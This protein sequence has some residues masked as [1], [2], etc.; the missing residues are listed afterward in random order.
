MPMSLGNCHCSAIGRLE[1]VT[2]TA[3]IF[4]K[5][6]S[7]SI[8]LNH[9]LANL[10]DMY[11]NKLLFSCVVEPPFLGSLAT[12]VVAQNR[13]LTAPLAITFE[14]LLR[15]LWEYPRLVHSPQASNRWD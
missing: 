9:F 1:P 14:G 2:V 8:N 12:F 4:N 7:S 13:N 10:T 3:N 15:Q 11:G 5:L 6:R